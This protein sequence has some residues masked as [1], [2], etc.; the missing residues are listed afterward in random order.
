MKK[1]LLTALLAATAGV[2]QAQMYVAGTVGLTRIGTDCT[3]TD[4]CD[5]TDAGGKVVLGY[6]LFPSVAFELGYIRFGAAKA[7]VY[8]AYIDY[9]VVMENRAK[10]MTVGVALKSA[11]SPSVDGVLRLGVAKVKSVVPVSL[12]G[13]GQLAEYSESKTKLYAGLGLDYAFSPS[14]KGVVSADFSK[15]EIS[16]ERATLRLLGVGFQYDF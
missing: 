7:T 15:G 2:A 14:L 9:P 1:F 4:T 13:Y 5:N 8:N 16:G 12:P 11:L 6:A 10:A 3:G